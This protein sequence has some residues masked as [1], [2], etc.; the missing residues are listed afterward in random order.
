VV[1]V[2]VVVGEVGRRREGGIYRQGGRDGEAGGRVAWSRRVTTES[3]ASGGRR[4]TR[5]RR[6]VASWGFREPSLLC[7]SSPAH[8]ILGTEV[9]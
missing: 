5:A 6:G 2:V 8:R 4:G 9:N 7:S 3:E 1:V